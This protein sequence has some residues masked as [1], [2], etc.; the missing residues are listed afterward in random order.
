MPSESTNQRVDGMKPHPYFTA[1]NGAVHCNACYFPNAMVHR[2]SRAICC[3][4]SCALRPRTNSP[5]MIVSDVSA[6]YRPVKGMC[7]KTIVN[8]L[9][10]LEKKKKAK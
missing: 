6:Q 3:S 4:F 7:K 1:Q 2:V 5:A 9:V 10:E 8:R